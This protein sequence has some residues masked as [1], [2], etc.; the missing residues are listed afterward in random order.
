MAYR[1]DIWAVEI[2]VRLKERDLKLH[3]VAAIPYLGFDEAWE[4]NW[5]QRYRRLLSLAEYVKVP[6]PAFSR[7]AYQKR[8]EWMVSHSAKVIAVYNGG[9]GGTRNT[10]LYYN[11]L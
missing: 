5:R 1:V 10:I 9:P 2:V 3:L 6:E 11:N 8:N 7:D 4:E